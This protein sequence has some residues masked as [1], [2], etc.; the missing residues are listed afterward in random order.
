VMVGAATVRLMVWLPL[1]G[2]AGP[3]VASWAVTVKLKAPTALG[4]PLIVPLLDSA[5]PAGSCP[6]VTRFSARQ[7]VRVHFTGSSSLLRGKWKM[8]ARLR[9]AS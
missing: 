8:A 4:V 3:V 2:A 7:Q 1:Y 9:A 6:A 5:R